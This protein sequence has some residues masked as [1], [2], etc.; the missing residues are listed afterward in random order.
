M[1][2]TVFDREHRMLGTV[3]TP[4][5]FIVSWIGEDL[6]LGIWRDEFDVEYVRGYELIKP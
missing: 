2:W 3:T 4:P 1:R 6:V 5:R